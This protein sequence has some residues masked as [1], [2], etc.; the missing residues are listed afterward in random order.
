VAIGLVCRNV[1]ALRR[2][3]PWVDFSIFDGSRLKVQHGHSLMAV[4]PNYPEKIEPGWWVSPRTGVQRREPL[5]FD[6]RQGQR[7]CSATMSLEASRGQRH[8][9]GRHRR[10]RD[11]GAICRCKMVEMADRAAHG[12]DRHGFILP[13]VSLARVRPP[14][15]EVIAAR[16]AVP[17]CFS[18][19][20]PQPLSHGQRRQ[21]HGWR[22]AGRRI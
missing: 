21:G 22:M 20:P 9:S 13:E 1:V 15:P 7:P 18:L 16:R 19:R 6:T 14:Y 12:L 5:G 8:S 17:S 11:C 3:Q 4:Q 10:K 2:E